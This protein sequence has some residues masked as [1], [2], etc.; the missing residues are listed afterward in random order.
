MKKGSMPPNTIAGSHVIEYARLD[1][2]VIYS[3]HSGL[4]VG[5]EE[6][7]PVPQLAICQK[8]SSD[9]VLLLHCERDWT[10]L[11]VAACKSVAE[12][13]GQAERTYAGSSLLW[14][15]PR[16]RTRKAERYAQDRTEDLRC[17]FCR[18]GPDQVEQ[19]IQKGDVRICDSC[20]Q[21]FHRMLH[22]GS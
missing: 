6:L 12:A 5:G 3:G 20:I 2:T 16:A 13:K 18:K 1:G 21:G 9:G 22:E 8:N 7:G 15:K 17:S 11:G 14:V 10:V 4:F 19:L